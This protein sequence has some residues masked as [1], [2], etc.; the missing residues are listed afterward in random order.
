MKPCSGHRE[1]TMPADDALLFI[2]ANKYL[3]LYRTA[4]GKKLLAS[5]QEQADHIFV[6]QQVV[7][8]VQ[9]NKLKE[10]AAFL[11][12]QFGE[13]RLQTFAVPDHLFGTDATQ[14]KNI[15]D[16][17]GEII[18]KIKR[19][20]KDVDTLAAAIMDQIYQSQDEV[21]KALAPIFARAVGHSPAE[22][23]R[24]QERRQRGNPPGKH[25]NAIG[26]QLTW[27]Q[28]LT[29]FAGKKRLWIISRDSD[30]S[31]VYEGKGYLNLFL[32]DEL[33]KLNPATEAF[34]FADVA[35]GIKDFADKTGVKADKLPSPEEAK[36]IKKEEEQLPPLDWLD[37]NNTLDVANAIA[38]RNWQQWNRG[39]IVQP[40]VVDEELPLGW[41]QPTQPIITR[42]PPPQHQPP[43]RP[44][45]VQNEPPPELFEVRQPVISR[46]PP[47]P[48]AQQPSDK[49]DETPAA[50]DPA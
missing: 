33:R 14:S 32:Y 37:G 13:L 9:R 35:D 7:E 47:P 22:L 48:Q 46:P 49:K 16:Q 19:L 17:M 10:A 20:K 36:E 50:D 21:S 38:R 31:T 3:D 11:A 41:L 4:S 39:G 34:L 23:Q 6:T 27:E 24:A 29:R 25:P 15:K 44:V 40:I 42:P 5:L 18:E 12:K 45:V 26:D 8:E 28:I 1:A 30:F 2:D 43:P